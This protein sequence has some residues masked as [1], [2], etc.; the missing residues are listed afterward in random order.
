MDNAMSA[1]PF[2]SDQ[3]IVIHTIESWV[4]SKEKIIAKNSF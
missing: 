2:Y 3:S 1:I 4:Q